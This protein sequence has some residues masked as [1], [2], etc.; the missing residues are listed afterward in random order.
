[1]REDLSEYRVKLLAVLE[2]DQVNEESSVLIGKLEDGWRGILEN[3]VPLS[4]H[5]NVCTSKQTPFKLGQIAW[6]IP[7][8]FYSI[9]RLEF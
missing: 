9:V 1:M 2:S 4:V 7:N 6:T 5:T 8:H 3:W